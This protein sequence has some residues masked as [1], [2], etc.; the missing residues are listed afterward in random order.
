MT[1]MDKR[2]IK[3]RIK[4]QITAL[5]KLYNETHNFGKNEDVDA[6]I[7]DCIVDSMRILKKGLEDIDK[8]W[9]VNY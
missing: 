9:K 8:Y 7:N 5:H 1:K 6:V 4:E 2:E 3:T